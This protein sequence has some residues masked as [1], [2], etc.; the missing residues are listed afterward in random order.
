MYAFST[1]NPCASGRSLSRMLGCALLLLLSACGGGGGS[2]T[3]AQETSPPTSTPVPIGSANSTLGFSLPRGGLGAA[4]LAVIVVD[5]DAQS[6]AIASYY[7]TARAIPAANI[8]RVKLNTASAT[9]SAPDFAALKAE[10]DAKLPAGV[11]ATLLT[12]TAPSRVVGSCAMSITSAMAFG[13]D[14]KYCGGCSSTASSSY[15]DSESKQAWVDHKIRPSMML[16]AATLAAAK[17][18]IDRGVRADASQPAGDGY[19]LRTSDE[20]RSVRFSDYTGLP[21]AWAGRLKLNYIDNSAGAAA[22]FIEAKAGVL[23]YFTGLA[24]VP[25]LSSV[26]FRPG[27]VADHLTSYGGLLPSSGQMPITDWLDAGA[28]AS[29]GT[30]EEPCSYTQKFPQASVLMEHYFRGETVIEAYWKSVQWPGQGLFVGEPLARPFPDSPSFTLDKTQYLISTRAL[31]P[32]A[33]YSL[34]YRAGA[35]GSWTALATF[36]VSRAEA[37]TLRS[38]LPPANATELRWR[39]PCANDSTLQCTQ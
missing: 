23:F 37:Q 22:D 33:S 1:A 31:R 39:G 26:S 25:K 20:A 13:F 15:F 16:G 30:V 35:A 14:S 5:G 11:Q 17:T 27:A 19:L 21:A 6:E 12:W 36:N 10:V 38:P 8:I 18:L 29:Y 28:T 24:N 9:I 32:K 4:E 3:N 34:E 2:A 7:Q